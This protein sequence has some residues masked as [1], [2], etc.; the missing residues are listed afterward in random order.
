[1]GQ[2]V[3]KWSITDDPCIYSA[4]APTLH[5]PALSPA[6]WLTEHAQGWGAPQLPQLKDEGGFWSWG[7]SADWPY[8]EK[9]RNHFWT[10]LI[11]WDPLALF[12]KISFLFL[13]VCIRVCVAGGL[14][15]KWVQGLGVLKEGVTCPRAEAAR[16]CESPN[17][18]TG[19]VQ[20]TF[21]RP[22]AERQRLGEGG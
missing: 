22:C 15:Y 11:L 5:L 7:Q 8:T 21:L 4:E 19:T 2:R 16:G 1:M 6:P 9:Y 12:L 13:I 3:R 17:T 14:L 10:A 20:H 18:G